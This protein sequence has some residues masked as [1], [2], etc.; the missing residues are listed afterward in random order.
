LCHEI[1]VTTAFLGWRRDAMTEKVVARGPEHGV[2]SN[3]AAHE[4]PS[5]AADM[6]RVYLEV[7][8]RLRR[9]CIS[10][11]RGAGDADDALQ[12]TFA[13][14]YRQVD[15][16]SRNEWIP[17]LYGIA[18][19]VVR[20]HARAGLRNAPLDAGVLA[21]RRSE[22]ASPEDALLGQERAARM[23]DALAELSEDRRAAL[24]LRAQEGLSCEEIA[25]ALGISIA[26]VKVDIHRARAELRQR[27]G[28]M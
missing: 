24:L 4:A 3:E 5:C 17:W 15:K 22:A 26:K 6:R 12:E 11:L 25:T 20:E 28:D 10:M 14:A 16:P 9:F 23:I 1:F 8:P 7:G 13:R 21:E 18:R 2:A 27:L 19:N